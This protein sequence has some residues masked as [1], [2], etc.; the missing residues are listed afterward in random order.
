MPSDRNENTETRHQL[1]SQDTH[2]KKKRISVTMDATFVFVSQPHT[3][4]QIPSLQARHV[5]EKPHTERRKALQRQ[6]M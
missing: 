6:M 5:F 4:D 1:L 2:E 3:V